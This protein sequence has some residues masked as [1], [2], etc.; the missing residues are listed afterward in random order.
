MFLGDSRSPSGPG[1]LPAQDFRVKPEVDALAGVIC[2][3]IVDM[4]DKPVVYYREEEEVH[5]PLRGLMVWM[6]AGQRSVRDTNPPPQVPSWISAG[7]GV[8]Q[9]AVG[10]SRW[11]AL[12]PVRTVGE[13]KPN[14][15]TPKADRKD[16]DESASQFVAQYFA[17][18]SQP[19]TIT[20]N[21][22]VYTLHS[23]T[24]QKTY[25]NAAGIEIGSYVY[26]SSG[27]V[28]PGSGW[29]PK[30]AT[31]TGAATTS[32]APPAPTPPPGYGFSQ[33]PDST[34]P[35]LPDYVYIEIELSPAPPILPGAP[36]APPSPAGFT[37]TGSVVTVIV[38]GGIGSNGTVRFTYQYKRDA[39]SGGGAGGPAPDPNHGTGDPDR[40]GSAGGGAALTVSPIV[41]TSYDPDPRFHPHAIPL[42]DRKPFWNR[43]P[44]DHFGVVV[45]TMDED[46]QVEDFLPTDPRLCAVNYAG[47]DA[48]GTLVCDLG[49][50]SE[51]DVTRMARLHSA[52]RV[53]VKPVTAAT[54]ETSPQGSGNAL[55][56]QFG[57][58]GQLDSPGGFVFDRQVIAKWSYHDGGCMHVG[59]FV[60]DKHLL[61][62]DGDRNSIN[63]MHLWTLG[64]FTTGNTI[65]DGPLHF[66]TEWPEPV[67]D[68]NFAIRVH[69]GWNPNARYPW[70]GGTLRGMWGWW[71]KTL[72][73]SETPGDPPPPPPGDGPR[74]PQ[75]PPP[76]P[77][78]KPPITPGGDPQTGGGGGGGPST[79]GGGNFSLRSTADD[80]YP[81]ITAGS[82]KWNPTHRRPAVIANE[83][84][85]PSIVARPQ[86]YVVG[87]P[88]VRYV[89]AAT[90]EQVK[91]YL[92][93]SPV[94]GRLSA[95]GQQK[96]SD[97]GRTQPPGYSRHRAGTG[98]GGWCIMPPE[99]GLEDLGESLAPQGV[100]RSST[101]WGVAPGASLGFGLPDLATG[102]MKTTM[103]LT[104]DGS[105]GLSFV[106]YDTSA[107]TTA[108]GGISNVGL[109]TLP[110]SVVRE[111]SGF[112]D[113]VVGS[114][115]DGEFV[116]RVGST[117]VGATPAGAGTVTS[118]ALTAPGEITVAGSPITGAG[119]L[120]LTW[121]N[122]T[123]NKVFASPNG[124]TGTPGFRALAVADMPDLSTVYQPLDA[125]LTSIA[126]LGSAAD[127]GLYTTGAHVWAEFALSAAGRA[128]V[129]DADA[130]AQRTTLG[131]GT[132]ATQSGTFSGTSSGTNTGDQTSVSGNAG[133]ATK[134]ATARNINGV[135]F[136]GTANVTVPAAG[137]TLTDTVPVANGGTGA[138]DASG[139][140]T[141]LGLGTIATQAIVGAQADSTAVLVSGIVSDFNS[142]LAKMRSSGVL[143]T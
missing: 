68:G 23:S 137:S 25:T 101:F 85:L 129:D 80:V 16:S 64:S 143:A 28:D 77:V 100:T 127:K 32:N 99:V 56:L 57:T 108:L 102:K 14:A 113:L 50:K 133:T 86:R 73:D 142:L 122:Q 5:G 76:P 59:P 55:A 105:G 26:S 71:T 114:V 53:I 21:G 117:L 118:V 140:R 72:I 70:R 92:R 110:V 18:G 65:H 1:L 29:T 49:S 39:V 84:S 66:E 115:A 79:G 7:T 51:Y 61:G 95:W 106:K 52:L 12:F 43:F 87:Q 63:A 103:A 60:G 48:C 112:T 11:Q 111:T 19:N 45:Q 42:E 44:R 78:G 9:R 88:D 8:G 136:D 46:K 104:A 83:L 109:V 121:A 120:A 62:Y 90:P 128:L 2:T 58:S 131:L 34:W 6:P 47:G 107:A 91:E 22:V 94:T 38:P 135:A 4:V 75:D 35:G 67:D 123:T 37:H 69:M 130:A 3:R 27:S 141:N 134:L 17:V 98:N 93:T 126:G 116:K 33:P 54:G 97:F 40:P 31:A 41:K 30:S 125:D 124:S 138:T 96:D 132:L 89:G 10:A 82:S 119:T 15:T 13:V 139:A 36:A 24:P 81:A 20:R 74:T